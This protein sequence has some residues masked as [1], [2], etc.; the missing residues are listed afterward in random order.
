MS[1]STTAF[2]AA[3]QTQTMVLAASTTGTSIAFAN[4]AQ[5]EFFGEGIDAVQIFNSDS[6]NTAWIKFDNANAVAAKIP[7]GTAPGDYPI[8]PLALLVMRVPPQ[9]VALGKVTIYAISS[10]GTPTLYLTPGEGL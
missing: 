7:S 9:V 3:P 4:A 10:T 6:S 5:Q 8:P 1:G 2:R